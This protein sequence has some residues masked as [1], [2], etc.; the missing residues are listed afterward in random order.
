[1]GA[2][3]CYKRVPMTKRNGN[4]GAQGHPKR[5]NGHSPRLADDELLAAL[6][7]AGQPLRS[8]RI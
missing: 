7:A 2:A 5:R 4:G 6:Q 3:L 1:M 8:K